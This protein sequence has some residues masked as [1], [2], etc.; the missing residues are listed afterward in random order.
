MKISW[1][2]RKQISCP[3]CS[4]KDTGQRIGSNEWHAVDCKNC[5]EYEIEDTAWHDRFQKDAAHVLT[6]KEKAKLAKWVKEHPNEN[7]T[8]MIL[9]TDKIDKIVG[10]RPKGPKP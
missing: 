6:A 5:G 8:P 9:W 4:E 7:F 3:L 10:R 1:G 2:E